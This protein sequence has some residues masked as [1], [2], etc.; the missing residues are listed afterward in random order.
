[1]ANQVSGPFAPITAINGAT[2]INATWANN[3]QTQAGVALASFNPDLVSACVLS[4][5]VATKDGT[6]ATQLDLTSGRAYLT[7]S[8]GTLAACAIG[9]DTFSAVGH[10]STTLYL[11][12]NPDG[13][14]SWGAAHSA[15]TN[16]LTI[17][18]VTT[19]GSANIA[20]VTDTSVRATKLLGGNPAQGLYVGTPGAAGSHV[21]AEVFRFGGAVASYGNDSY[22]GTYADGAGVGGAFLY[23]VLAA[24]K[25]VIFT[26]QGAGGGNLFAVGITPTAGAKSWID[27]AGVLHTTAPA[28]L[29]PG[30]QIVGWSCGCA[31]TAT[32]A[33]QRLAVMVSFPC[34]LTNTPTSVTLSGSG[35]NLV[36]GFPATGSASTT[37]FL[38]TI[39]AAAAGTCSWTGTYTTA[40]N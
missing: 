12:L 28:V 13:S 14:W 4:G 33:N 31:F 11:D 24:D 18:S 40:G 35:S 39:E 15:V 29:A 17:A 21:T 37:G 19:D 9:A 32:A 34:Q 8:D 2:P 20:T 36:A 10:P 3:A 7:Q 16:H 27:Q 5:A 22:I 6:L 26:Q 23:L 30:N 38:L 25:G 1:M